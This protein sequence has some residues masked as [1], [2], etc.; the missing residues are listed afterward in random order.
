MHFVA[1][2]LTERSSGSGVDSSF[3]QWL[4]PLFKEV[5][6]YHLALDLDQG[7]KASFQVLLEG[8][9]RAINQPILLFQVTEVWGLVEW[10]LVCQDMEELYLVK[11]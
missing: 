4:S 3:C 7:D 1:R 2:W 9:L 6:T 10:G 5:C 11:V 8:S